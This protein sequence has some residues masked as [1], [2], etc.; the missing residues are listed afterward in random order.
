V[1]DP[2]RGPGI[3]WRSL[4]GGGHRTDLGAA[5]EGI[6]TARLVAR[7]HLGSAECCFRVNR[8]VP[9]EGPFGSS[10]SSNSEP[11]GRDPL[12]LVGRHRHAQSKQQASKQPQARP[13]RSS[14]RSP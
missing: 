12:H 9:V 7:R 2:A 3:A 8:A 11:P 1:V 5:F 14:R 10:R 6:P 4:S 13:S